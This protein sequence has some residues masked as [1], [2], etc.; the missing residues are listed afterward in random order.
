[1]V[2]T[3]EVDLSGLLQRR[4]GAGNK[5]ASAGR[6][7]S[8]SFPVVNP[9]SRHLGSVTVRIKVLL[10]L[11]PPA[12]PPKELLA[13]NSWQVSAGTASCLSINPSYKLNI[14]T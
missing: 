3:V 1:M 7:L 12:E 5:P 6:W 11:Q 14:S 8:G 10:E 2:G 4:P 9:A 13:A